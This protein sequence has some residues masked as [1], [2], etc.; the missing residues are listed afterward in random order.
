MPIW[1]QHLFS[2]LMKPADDQGGDLGGGSATEAA[3]DAIGADAPAELPEESK[4]DQETPAE[5]TD[6]PQNDE[7]AAPEGGKSKLAAMLDE[8]TDD[9]NAPKPA[10]SKPDQEKPAEPA[11]AEDKPKAPEQE[12]AELLEGVKSE[13][14]KERIKQVF[15][16]KKQLE[17]DINEFRELVKSTGMSAQEFAQTLEFGRLVSSGD[18][19]NL[20]VALEMVE[21]QRA[22]LYQKLGVEAPGVD[23]LQGHDDLKQAVDNMEIT[24]ERAVELAKYR[25]QQQEVQQRQQVERQTVQQQQEF[26]QQ[27]Q[28]AAQSMEAYL[29]TRAQEI[30]HPARMKVITDHFKNP[31]NLQAFVSTYQP[32][33]WAA[34]IKMMYDNIQVPRAAASP[35]P[36][37]S[38][39]AAL[40]NPA[41][42]A[43]SPIDR[44]AQRMESM[45]L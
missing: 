30:D 24:R 27:V 40:G 45:G 18:E 43:A 10:E 3:I 11:K 16:E 32:H 15:A 36:I 44:I 35:Q 41:P 6:A 29:Q 13:R 9:P 4:P 2:R 8:L 19:K 20:R 33:Q 5:P 26:Q 22:M 38:R 39:P 17:Q 7:G 23:L 25:K 1:N 34:T 31:A 12:E 37:R 14:G 21:S 28:Q 42:N